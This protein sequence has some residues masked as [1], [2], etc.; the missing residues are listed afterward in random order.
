MLC[1]QHHLVQVFLGAGELAIGGEG[2]GDVR[3]IAVQFATRVDQHQLAIANRRHIGAVMQHTGVGTRGDDG[4]VGGK[5]RA[6]Q[7]EL[8]QQLGIQVVLTHILAGTQHASAGLHGTYMGVGTDTGGAA[9]GVLL[10]GVFHQAHFIQQGAQVL[11]RRGAGHAHAHPGANLGEPAVHLC[12]QCFV[13]GKREPHRGLV[14][15]Q[16]G[17]FFVQLAH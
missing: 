13:G 12:G 7:T 11:L 6:V 9:H 4:G 14:F 1:G 10:M 17:Q 15:Q 2:A 5:L 3:G 8:V 16:F